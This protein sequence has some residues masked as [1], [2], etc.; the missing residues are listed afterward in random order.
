LNKKLY[1][2]GLKGSKADTSLFYYNN[3]GIC[4]FILVYVDDIIVSR[5]KHEGVIALLQDL[6]K[7]FM[8]KDLGDLNYYLRIEVRNY[9][10]MKGLH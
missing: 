1:D 4:M 9:V 2:L 7:Y 10:F 8:L 3:G 6:K 5:L